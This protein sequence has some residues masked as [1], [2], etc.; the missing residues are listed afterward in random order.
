MTELDVTV[1]NDHVHVV[2]AHILVSVWSPVMLRR[3][4]LF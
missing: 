3:L 1:V 4:L 2:R